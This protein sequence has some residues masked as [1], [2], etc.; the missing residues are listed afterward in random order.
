VRTGAWLGQFA[1]PV[2]WRTAS[3]PLLTVLR[4][5]RTNR[6]ELTTADR[7]VVR[8][9]LEDDIRLLGKLTGIEVDDWLG[10][11]GR[12]AYSVRRS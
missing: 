3:K 8:A 7:A 10:Q 9:P 1:P 4:G 12:G 2:V 6:P 11:S 5:R